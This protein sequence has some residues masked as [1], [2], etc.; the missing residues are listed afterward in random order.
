MK[1]IAKFVALALATFGAQMI[2]T[3]AMAQVTPPPSKT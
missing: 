1:A 2:S 3:S